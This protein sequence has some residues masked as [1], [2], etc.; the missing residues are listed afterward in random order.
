M[1]ES[2]HDAMEAFIAHLRDARDASAHT[3]RAYARELGDLR[4]WL[5][6]HAP[7]VATVEQLGATTLRAYVA[8]RADGKLAPASVAR[9]VATLRSF[10]RFLATTERVGGNPA[11][12]LRAPRQGRALPHWLE[13]AE[14]DRLL[15]APEGDDERACRDRA[16][17]ETLY[18]TG[19]RV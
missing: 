2:L 13:T 18:S 12:L 1:A 5:A 17:L 19:M 16:L 8:D 6:K 14:V 11:A 3:V 10:G 15:A 4:T 9:V 7:E